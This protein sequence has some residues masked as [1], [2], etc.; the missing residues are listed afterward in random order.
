MGENMN[1]VY[2]QNLAMIVTDNCNLN[3]AHCMRGKSCNNNMSKEVIKATLSQTKAI[4]NLN[5]CGGEPTLALD[6]IEEIFKYIIHNRI[7]VDQISV[8]TNGTNYSLDF[9]TLLHSMRAYVPRK[10]ILF[11]ISCDTYHQQELKR[12]N[13]VDIY[14]ENVKRY[15][16]FQYFGGLHYLDKHLK[17]Y[18]EGNAK[19]LNP[20]LTVALKP[21]DIVVTYVGK[22]SKYDQNGLCNIDPCIAVNTKGIITE[23]NASIE[24]QQTL[25]N[26]GDVFNDTFE[27][28][29]LEKGKIL[30]PKQWYRQTGKIIKKQMTYNK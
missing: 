16:D 27:E 29:A 17:L 20:N 15:S 6:T 7:L 23:A 9:L 25:Y 19:N 14:L 12:L 13:M 3:C 28:I 22:A 26:Y 10:N 30:K 5:L 24:H 4:G 11:Q 21:I 1:Q 2:I 8:V 18:R